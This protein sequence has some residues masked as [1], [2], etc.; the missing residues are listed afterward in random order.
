MA[1]KTVREIKE[2]YVVDESGKRVSVI[3]DPRANSILI[4]GRNEL[5]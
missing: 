1:T 2:H 3:L 4:Y 5:H